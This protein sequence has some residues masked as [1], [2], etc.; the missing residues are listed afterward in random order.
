M[1]DDEPEEYSVVYL[2]HGGSVVDEHFNT[3]AEAEGRLRY[4]SDCL[5]ASSC[6]VK[7][8]KDARDAF[9]F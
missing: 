9:F 7:M 1:F 2:F 6:L 4:L 5:G 8:E 3:K